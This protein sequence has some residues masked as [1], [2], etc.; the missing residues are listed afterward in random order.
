M[1]LNIKFLENRLHFIVNFS[2]S[3]GTIQNIIR[4]VWTQNEFTC[5]HALV[6]LRNSVLE[7]AKS[8]LFLYIRL[9]CFVHDKSSGLSNCSND[10]DSFSLKELSED[11]AFEGISTTNE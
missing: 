5:G 2:Y 1:S 6:I 3:V 7:L 4:V 8:K 10:P 11:E 9:E